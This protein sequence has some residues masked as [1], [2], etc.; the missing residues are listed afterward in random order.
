[1]NSDLRQLLLNREPGGKMEEL[2]RKLEPLALI[3][4]DTQEEREGS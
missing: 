3:T 4:T 2:M 1:M